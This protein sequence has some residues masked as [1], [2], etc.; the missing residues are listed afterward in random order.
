M[1]SFATIAG[2]LSPSIVLLASGLAVPRAHPN[3]Q[4]KSR[5]TC[6]LPTTYSW[7]DFGGPLAEPD[8]NWASLK[9]FTVSSVDGKYIIYGSNY[10]GAN[11]GSFAFE[12][13]SDFT[14]L[15]STPQI[16]MDQA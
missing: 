14:V 16:P 13:V 2:V 7:T 12:P 15:S 9:D 6:E 11:Y 10:N 5:Q 4:L 8:N 3:G 1:P